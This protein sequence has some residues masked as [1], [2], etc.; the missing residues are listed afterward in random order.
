MLFISCH[1]LVAV[2]IKTFPENVFLFASGYFFLN[3]LLLKYTIQKF[4]V[5]SPLIL[6]ENL[7]KLI[8]N[9]ENEVLLLL[10]EGLSNKDIGNK[11]YISETTVKSHVKSIYKKL[12]V[13]NRIQLLNLFKN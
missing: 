10:A 13:K 9:R 2:V 5:P 7:D 12:Q 8:S 6:K 11:L 1:T 4:F 3:T